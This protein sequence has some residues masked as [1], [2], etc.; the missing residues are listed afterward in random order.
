MEDA[1]TEHLDDKQFDSKEVFVYESPSDYKDVIANATANSDDVPTNYMKIHDVSN[2]G[3]RR[4]EVHFVIETHTHIMTF[5]LE[6]KKTQQ[7]RKF[8]LSN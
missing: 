5:S 4:R 7:G 1:D 6:P 3:Y 2:E 8:E